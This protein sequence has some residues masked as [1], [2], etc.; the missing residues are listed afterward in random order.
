MSILD[1]KKQN[2]ELN[3]QEIITGYSKMKHSSNSIREEINYVNCNLCNSNKFKFERVLNNYCLVKCK[4][5]GFVYVNPRLKKEIIIDDYKDK[6]KYSKKIHCSG[7]DNLIK[8]YK[9]TEDERILQDKRELNLIKEVVGSKKLKILDVGCGNLCF[10]R[11]AKKTGHKVEGMD[12]TN[13]Q[14]E[15]AKK[16]K[17]PF[18]TGTLK[19]IRL[20]KNRFD[21]IRL[22]QVLEHLD[23]PSENLKECYRI[24]KS[25]GLINI[26][27]P[28]YG[29]LSIKLGMDKF[30]ANVPPG[31]LNY[32]TYKTLKKFLIKSGFREIKSICDWLNN[33]KLRK[34]LFYDRSALIKKFIKKQILNRFKLSNDLMIMA[35]KN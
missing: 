26:S 1:L 5:C 24:L 21:F 33:K 15:I 14:R 8:Y 10:L 9:R 16:D 4:K 18:Y 34:I 22:N 35:I 12:I 30:K 3:I 6:N 2:K 28:N 17:I 19:E 11:V 7:K 31:H 13:W 20:D 23:D 25:E 29:A 27:V 32:F